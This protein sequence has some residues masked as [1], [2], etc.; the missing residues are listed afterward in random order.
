MWGTLPEVDPDKVE[1]SRSS[2]LEGNN[3]RRQA[4]IASSSFE[5]LVSKNA[6]RMPAVRS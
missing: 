4:R 2:G 1:Q 5:I 3:R 6:S